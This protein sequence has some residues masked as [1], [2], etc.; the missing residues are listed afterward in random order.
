MSSP[1]QLGFFKR[2]Y[3]KMLKNPD[4]TDETTELNS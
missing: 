4:E 1:S 3:E 2:Q